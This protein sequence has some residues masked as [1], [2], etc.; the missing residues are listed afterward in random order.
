[1]RTHHRIKRADK[2][3]QASA[4]PGRAVAAGQKFVAKCLTLIT[5]GLLSITAA[6][7]S[8]FRTLNFGDSCLAAEAAEYRLGNSPKTGA[9]DRHNQYAFNGVFLDRAVTIV[10]HCGEHG[11]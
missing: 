7:A 11:Q 6:A 9:A 2:R 3:P 4:A 8:D 1:M 10:Y 5:A